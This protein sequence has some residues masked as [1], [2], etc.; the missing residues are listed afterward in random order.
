MK[1]IFAFILITAL[2]VIA[3]VGCAEKKPCENGHS[4][5]NYISDNN[6]TCT[7]DGTKTAKCDNC[8][9]TDVKTE[10]DSK[11]AHTFS[12]EVVKEADCVNEGLIK[13]TCTVCNTT[14]EVTVDAIGHSFNLD[15]FGYQ[16]AEGHAHKCAVCGEHD[17]LI[18]HTPGA[19]ATETEAQKCTVCEY[20]IAAPLGHTHSFIL[21]D[22][23]E[24]TLKSAANCTDAAKYYKSCT[25]GAVSDGDVFAVGEALGHDFCE[26]NCTDPKT[27]KRCPVTEGAALGHNLGEWVQY[28]DPTYSQEGEDRRECSRCDH[29]ESKPI[30]R[31]ES[32]IDHNA[33]A[34][35]N[36]Q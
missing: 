22:A 13:K 7:Q 30:D 27:C 26:A 35:V 28:K 23:N 25:C 5:T 34:P 1:R 3:L 8:D 10:A 21:E 17:T 32:N 24:V 2:A 12:E 31:L 18:P 6:A 9:A 20:V 29:Y 11:K 19:A 4:F 16:S 36:P 33:W 15:A 14:E